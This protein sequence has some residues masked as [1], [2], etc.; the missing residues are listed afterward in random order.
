MNKTTYLV[1]SVGI[2][3][4]W[5]GKCGSIEKKL[6]SNVRMRGKSVSRA[7]LYTYVHMQSF[8]RSVFAINGESEDPLGLAER[9]SALPQGAV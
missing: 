9:I 1:V 5:K 4:R 7:A 8:D 2:V 3:R 6:R